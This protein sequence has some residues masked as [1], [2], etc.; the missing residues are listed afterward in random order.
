MFA[1]CLLQQGRISA[2]SRPPRQSGS[3]YRPGKFADATLLPAIKRAGGM[4]LVGIASPG[5][6][7]ARHAAAKFGFAFASSSNADILKDRRINTVAI[8]TPHDS[9]AQLDIQALQ[10]GRHVFVEKPLAVT[11][12]QLIALE[13]HL[14]K[15]KAHLLT[16][17]FNRRF[18]PLSR[19]LAEFFSGRLEPLHA[20]YRINAGYLPPDHWT[21]D[22][23][24]GGRILGEACHF[25]DL[26]TF[27]IGSPPTAVCAHALPDH[28]KYREDNVSM[29][30]TFP[31]GS[32]GVVDYLANGDASFPKEKLDVFCAG[33]S[34]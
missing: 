34:C 16:V 2:G 22:P 20:H 24:Q 13:R 11:E 14:R 8:L 4:D 27:L 18:S 5:G 25:V 10:A 33:K 3:A 17:G 21:Q 23:D 12:A 7:H 30:F 1:W 19:M 15:E 32:I 26:I 6:L 31:D 29:T 28:G 9:H